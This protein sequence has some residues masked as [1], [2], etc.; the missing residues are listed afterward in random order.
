MAAGDAV[1]KGQQWKLHFGNLAR[2]GY[3]PTAWT[4]KDQDADDETVPDERGAT[5]THILTNPRKL[6]TGDLLIKDTGS[7]TPPAKGDYIWLQGP[8]DAAALYYYVDDAQVSFSSG[9]TR[10]SLSLLLEDSQSNGAVFDDTS[11]QQESAD[12]SLGSPGDVAEVLTVNDATDVVAVKVS[13]TALTETT[14]WTFTGGDTLTIK[15][16]Y[17]ETVLTEEDDSLEVWIYFDVGAPCVLTI[18]AVE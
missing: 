3:L 1:Q 15:N 6:M 11:T 14:H 5:I 8:A 4:F 18:T 7:I 12:Y 17:L 10:L 9:I 16:A 2:T 13:N